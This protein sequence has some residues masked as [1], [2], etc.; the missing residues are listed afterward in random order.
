MNEMK[1]IEQPK[2]IAKLVH[3]STKSIIPVYK[4]LNWFQRLMIRWFFGL[5]YE[6]IN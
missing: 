1:Y 4:P 5:K 6:R 2:A 3:K